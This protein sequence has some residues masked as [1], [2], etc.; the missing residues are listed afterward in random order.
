[1]SETPLSCKEEGMKDE[2]SESSRRRERDRYCFKAFTSKYGFSEPQYICNANMHFLMAKNY[3]YLV[4]F[5]HF[6][7]D[8]LF[9]IMSATYLN[10]CRKTVEEG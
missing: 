4:R 7:L 6:N 3:Y 5:K 8:V 10:L 2:S 1:M 9:F